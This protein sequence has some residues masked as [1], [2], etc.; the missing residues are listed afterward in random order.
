M[1]K[2]FLLELF[3]F[4]QRSIRVLQNYINL[5]AYN[6]TSITFQ[7]ALLGQTGQGSGMLGIP[8]DWTPPSRFV[9]MTTF[10]RFVL[11]TKNAIDTV[12]LAEHL[13]NTVDIP[14][15]MIR[16]RTSSGANLES[17][18]WIVIKDQ[19]NKVFYF[20]SYRE[21]A[22]KSIDMKRIQFHPGSKRAISI[23]MGRGPIDVT[24]SLR[25]SAQ[26]PISDALESLQ[27]SEETDSFPDLEIKS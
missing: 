1:K 16:E 23:D 22:L 13:L 15:G 2:A 17:T 9:R 26:P 5:T 20:R 24:S 19:T 14:L 18:Q 21:L 4:L 12:N 8:G 3:G 7:G 10:L 11:Q 6:I 27:K 25:T